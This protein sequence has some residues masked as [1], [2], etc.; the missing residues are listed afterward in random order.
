MKK[1]LITFVIIAILSVIYVQTESIF[2]VKNEDAVPTVKTV[3]PTIVKVKSTAKKT[4]ASKKTQTSKKVT[5]PKNKSKIVKEQLKIINITCSPDDRFDGAKVYYVLIPEINLKSNFKSDIKDLIK[6]LVNKYQTKKISIWI[7]DNK[8][9]FNLYYSMY[10]DLSLNRP[11]TKAENKLLE[12]HLI[13]CFS[14]DCELNS[15]YLNEMDFFPA[16]FKTSN[17][18]GKYVEYGKEFNP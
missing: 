14:G 17:I 7:L 16:A 18:I 11:T 13:S 12:R 9:A 4:Q 8:K 3:S 10:G 6:T 15:K 1:L 5:T 2:K